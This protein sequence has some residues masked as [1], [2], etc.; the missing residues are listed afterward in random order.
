MLAGA[1][2]VV[3]AAVVILFAAPWRTKAPAAGPFTPTVYRSI[4]V[5]PL[6]NYSADSAQAYFAEGMTDELT[7]DLATI[8]SLRVISRGSTMQY[9]GRN[10]PPTP[11]IARALNVDAIVEGSVTRAGD[12]VRI[13]AQLIDARA[14][15]HL[16]ARSFERNS[17]DVLAL[18]AELASAIAEAINVQLTPG[19][20]TRLAAAPTVDPAA[21][22]AYL[23]GRYFFARPSDQNLEK[24]IALFNE[25]VQLSPGFAPAWSG[26]SDAYLWA[27]FN[28]GFISA[29]EAGPKAQ[30]AAK[31]AVQLDSSAAEGHASLGTW[32]AWF[33]H[34]WPGSERELRHAIA[35]NPNY[36][37]AHDQFGLMLG[38]LGRFDEAIAEGKRAMTLDP[39]SPSILIDALIPFQ[40]QHNLPAARA[41]AQ[42]AADLDPTFYFP[43]LAE[44]VLDLQVGRFREAVPV[45]EKAR[46]M[47][48]PSFAT[49]YLAYAYGKAGDQAHALATLADLKKMSRS[50]S[51]LPFDLALFHLGQGD[52]RQALD[53]LEQAFAANAQSLVWLKEDAI[54]DPLRREPRFIALMRRMH[55]TP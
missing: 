52:T 31:R 8:S 21:H 17:S 34:D 18:Q 53:Y 14:D 26:L 48:A 2:A 28:D 4:A 20:Q 51:G 36:A 12:K 43:S 16:W 32:L 7:T 5:L 41:L 29:L 47:G 9:A 27:A 24:A 42:R 22:D 49:A 25:A 50:G 23:K 13:T 1:A 30:A 46:T 10:R 39:L 6:D 33:A 45:L 38:F 44:G 19:E 40:F 37:F 54:Y 35:L 3:I 11:E 15:R 55:F